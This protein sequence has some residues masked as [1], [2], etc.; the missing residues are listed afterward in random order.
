MPIH[1]R[2][3]IKYGSCQ[4]GR[5]HTTTRGEIMPITTSLTTL[6]LGLGLA[7]SGPTVGLPSPS[8]ANASA[9]VGVAASAPSI[10]QFDPQHV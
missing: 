3:A 7:F 1:G 4:D 6:V 9:L 5:K 2:S 8:G 10:D